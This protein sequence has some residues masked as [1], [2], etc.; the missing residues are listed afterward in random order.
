MG[1]RRAKL[2]IDI[3]E[4][5]ETHGVYDLDT[6]GWLDAMRDFVADVLENLRDKKDFRPPETKFGNSMRT[7]RKLMRMAKTARRIPFIGKKLAG[8]DPIERLRKFPL[9]SP[10]TVPEAQFRI[11]V[12]GELLDA[13]IGDFRGAPPGPPR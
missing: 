1:L 10:G 9:P 6:D 7:L 13:E 5:P 11:D 4:L 12:D 8:F 2:G 3:A